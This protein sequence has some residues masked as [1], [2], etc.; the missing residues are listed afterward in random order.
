MN[1]F[2]NN[3]NGFHTKKSRETRDRKR[4]DQ[5]SL[6]NELCV[7]EASRT[8]RNRLQEV[9]LTGCRARKVSLLNKKYKKG[10]NLLDDI[11]V[12]KIGIMCWGQMKQRLICLVR[13]EN[14]S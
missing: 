8:I 2:K 6:K 4:F 5:H 9:G 14:C 12:V 3:V 7:P 11:C 10:W 1:W 13:T